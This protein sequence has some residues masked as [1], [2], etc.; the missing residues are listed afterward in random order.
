MNRIRNRTSTVM[1]L[2]TWVRGQ[3]IVRVVAIAAATVVVAAGVLEAVVVGVD[4]AD[5]RAVAVVTVGTVVAAGADTKT[6][7]PIPRI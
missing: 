6:L 4:V 1:D 2:H 7:P 3:E 5:G